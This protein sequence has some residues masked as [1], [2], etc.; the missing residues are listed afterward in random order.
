MGANLG[1]DIHSAATGWTSDWFFYAHSELLFA[2]ILSE[3]NKGT[4]RVSYPIIH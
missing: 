1:G 2:G 4:N 3:N